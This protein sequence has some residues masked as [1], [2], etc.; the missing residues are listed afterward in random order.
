MLAH[1]NILS[2]GSFAIVNFTP[3]DATNPEKENDTVLTIQIQVRGL[4]EG[5]YTVGL[6]LEGKEEEELG[7]LT[8]KKNGSGSFHYNVTSPQW[9]EHARRLRIE[10]SGVLVLISEPF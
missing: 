3:K 9:D 7:I 6:R 2:E 10:D 8:I 1:K 4:D 5:E